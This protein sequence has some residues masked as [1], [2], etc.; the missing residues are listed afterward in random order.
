MNQNSANSLLISCINFDFT[1]SVSIILSIIGLIGNS[2]SI[3]IITKEQFRRA[4]LFRYLA[5]SLI[6]DTFVL[7]TM[8]LYTLP[9][10][11]Q[12]TS[13]GCKL[14][15][16]FGFLFYQ[17]C[18]WIIVA[19]SIDRVFSV[20]FPTKYKFRTKLKFQILI[21]TI[22]FV[23]VMFLNIPLYLNY[24]IQTQLNQ[25]ICTINNNHI[26]FYTDLASFL[27]SVIIPFII[28]I[29]CTSTIGLHMIK[30]KKKVITK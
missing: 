7:V 16:Y 3:F 23:I 26:Q 27:V 22:I 28:M 2:T 30:N 13:L 1:L 8:W 10:V 17:V 24:D 29:V 14:T 11:F 20:K 5:F 4:S 15:Q 25:T 18:P 6:N 12:M 9:V 21:I 19:G